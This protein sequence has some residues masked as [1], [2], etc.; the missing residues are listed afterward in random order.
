MELLN[1][2]VILQILLMRSQQDRK[3]GGTDRMAAVNLERG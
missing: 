3:F 2:L 1:L